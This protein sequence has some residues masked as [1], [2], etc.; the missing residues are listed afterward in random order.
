MKRRPFL[1]RFASRKQRP[2]AVIGVAWYASEHTWA[3]MKAF[4]E[5]PDR[6]ENSYAEWEA[7]ASETV[8]NFGK[9]GI[10]LVRVPIEPEVFRQW[11]E[12]RSGKNDA[13]SRAAYASEKVGDYHHV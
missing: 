1:E 5:D 8:A 3:E 2:K 13:N 10:E 4:A 11:L 12:T 6:Y 9:Q 7:I